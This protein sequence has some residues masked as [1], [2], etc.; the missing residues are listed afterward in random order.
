ML[1][2]TARGGGFDLGRRGDL[3][4]FKV[5]GLERKA[6]P[7]GV[8]SQISIPGSSLQGRVGD[9]DY[10]GRMLPGLLVGFSCPERQLVAPNCWGI[11]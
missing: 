4:G 3:L 11:N 6:S 7:R 8:W 10:P 2:L 9:P 1:S 5:R